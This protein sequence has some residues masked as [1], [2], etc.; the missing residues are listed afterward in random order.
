MKINPMMC[1]KVE[2]GQMGRTWPGDKVNIMGAISN[3]QTARGV[4]QQNRITVSELN[5]LNPQEYTNKAVYCSASIQIF[6][7]NGWWYRSCSTQSV[8]N[9]CKKTRRIGGH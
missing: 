8:T 6:S 4:E 3:Y 5:A 1:Q 9:N 7:Q 2:L